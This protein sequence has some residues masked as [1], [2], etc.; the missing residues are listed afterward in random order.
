ME[1]SRSVRLISKKSARPTVPDVLESIGNTP[2]VELRRMMPK[3][4]ARILA[5]LE[6]H[7]PGGS[8]KDRPAYWMV[9]KAEESG[10]LVPGKVILEP[11][12]GNTGI[13]LAL[14]G[15][16]KGYRVKLTLPECVS[17]ERR[18]ILLAY[19]AELVLTPAHERTDGAIRAAHRIMEEA[20]ERY[21]MPNQ[22]ANPDNWL[23]HYETTGAEILA[24]TGGDVACFVAGMGTTGTLMG[25]GRRLKEH[26]PG[27]RIV[28]V[29]PVEGHAI[30][31]LKNMKESIVPQ[32]Y[33]R[34]RLDQV[35]VVE[36]RAA[37]AM[38]NRLALE[39]GLF[40]GMSS[41]AAL[42]GALQVAADLSPGDTVVVLLPDRGDRYLST[43]LFRSICAE[44]P[45]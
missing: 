15:A 32:I 24:Q 40:V 30:Q 13:G 9:R 34:D 16:C 25:V 2:L 26:H 37:F 12:S 31:G 19:G 23:S 27:V 36:D 11:T 33:E 18:Q 3:G 29:E 7:N 22:F 17:T 6:G 39:E 42:C 10:R 43:N 41:G 28:G 45:P 5:K 38:T 14:V 44:C 35:I 20:P 1:E 8:V 4:R 21:F